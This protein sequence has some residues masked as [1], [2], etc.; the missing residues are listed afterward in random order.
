[1]KKLAVKKVKILIR[2]KKKKVQE[3]GFR[4]CLLKEA[5]K[6]FITNFSAENLPD[7]KTVEVLISGKPTNVDKFVMRVKEI[8]RG[9]PIDFEITTERYSGS[10]M[11]TSEYASYLT[12]GQLVIGVGTLGRIDSRLGS[13][14]GSLKSMNEFNAAT[15]KGITR[16]VEQL[17]GLPKRLS[18]EMKEA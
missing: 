15:A 5:Q 18:K 16:I 11:K 17:D 8:G 9:N 2:E 4:L 7:G 3:V 6:Q 13:I 12:A 1:V 14:D 10:I